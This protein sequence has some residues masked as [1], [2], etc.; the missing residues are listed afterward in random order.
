MTRR[1]P[2]ARKITPLVVVAVLLAVCRPASAASAGHAAWTLGGVEC[3]LIGPADA[4]P[5]GVGPCPGVRPGGLVRSDKGSCTLNFLFAGSDG[6][7]Y[8]GTAG[9]CILGDSVFAEDVGEQVWPPGTGPP[10]TDA[11]GAR[12]GEFAYA[13]LQSPKDFALIRL[14]PGVAASSQMCHF[15]GPTGIN[16]DVSATPVTLHH[17]GNGLVFGSTVSARTHVAPA[18]PDRD[19]VFAWGAAISGD[20][21]SGVISSDG[22]AVG[23]LV[24]VG[25]HFGQIGTGGTESGL[26]GITRLQPQVER[27]AQA[28]GVSLTIQ[29]ASQL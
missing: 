20:S 29:T 27:A 1:K 9:H 18:M 3:R 17:R 16:N 10:A 14:D 22:R 7:R 23:V 13:V 8:I 11:G 28:L 21:G 5:F 24:T 15:G 4:P 6:G 26:I 12:I 19:H 2:P 25:G